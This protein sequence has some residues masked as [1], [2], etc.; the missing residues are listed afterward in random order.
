MQQLITQNL[1]LHKVHR[2][3]Q[4]QIRGYHLSECLLFH[5]ENPKEST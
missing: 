5:L 1:T 4:T 2:C 3:Y